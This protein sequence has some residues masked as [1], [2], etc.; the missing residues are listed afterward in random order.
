MSID[1][2]I[3]YL[4]LCLDNRIVSI[5]SIQAVIA[6][7]LFESGCCCQ[8]LL[9]ISRTVTT[10][11]RKTPF[12]EVIWLVNCQASLRHSVC[13]WVMQA[14]YMNQQLVVCTMLRWLSCQTNT[15]EVVDL[16]CW[17]RVDLHGSQSC[18]MTDKITRVEDKHCCCYLS[19]SACSETSHAHWLVTT[20]QH[21]SVGSVHAT[22]FDISRSLQC[23]RWTVSRSMSG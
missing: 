18:L 9:V 12:P 15:S 4:V 8:V 2:L 20:P 3:H 6:A 10:S 1:I 11:L 14:A 13:S 21:T 17:C 7:V 16:W 22:D 19:V 23:Q 5:C